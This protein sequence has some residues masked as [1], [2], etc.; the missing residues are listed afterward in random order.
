[1]GPIAPG[2]SVRI[3][4]IDTEADLPRNEVGEI[5]VKGPN[6]FA[7]YLGDENVN[8]GT[9]DSHGYYKTGDIGIIDDDSHIQITDRAK[10]LIKYNGFQ[11]SVSE[12]EGE[13][14]EAIDKSTC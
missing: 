14:P 2:L 12:I 7:G 11:V 1:M 6:V 5:R 3:V 9:F 10:D 8:A 4:N 13:Y